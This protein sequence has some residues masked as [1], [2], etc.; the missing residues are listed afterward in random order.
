MT[1]YLFILFYLLVGVLLFSLAKLQIRRDEVPYFLRFDSIAAAHEADIEINVEAS[2]P[3]NEQQLE[4]LKKDYLALWAHLNA[5]Y[6]TNDLK[7]SKDRFTERIYSNLAIA[8]PGKTTGLGQRKD[9]NHKLLIQNWSRDGLACQMIDSLQFAYLLPDSAQY[10]T[11]AVL[12]LSLVY[13]G[14]NWR[15]D[16]IKFI[17]EK[18]LSP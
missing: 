14:D 17:D 1:R 12:A 11:D 18:P 15:L 7:P 6:E 4:V 16:G 13:Q 2:F 9:L 10:Q 3:P 5:I 8:Y